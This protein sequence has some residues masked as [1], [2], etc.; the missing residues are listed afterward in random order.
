[1]AADN[2][3]LRYGNIYPKTLPKNTH[4]QPICSAKSRKNF[5]SR[6]APSSLPFRL[7]PRAFPT[8]FDS[9]LGPS[10]PAGRMRDT[11]KADGGDRRSSRAKVTHPPP[12]RRK[13]TRRATNV[14]QGDH[15]HPTV[16]KGNTPSPYLPSSAGSFH[17]PK[18]EMDSSPTN[19]GGEG[20]MCYGAQI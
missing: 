3:A 2:L 11:H 4:L 20:E 14:K 7:P 5:A 18:G 10:R 13:P 19:N 12:P 15:P 17:P 6:R 8:E 1:M 16:R 9:T